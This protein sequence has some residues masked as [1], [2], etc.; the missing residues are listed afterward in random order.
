MD[1]IGFV[2]SDF[3]GAVGVKDSGAGAIAGGARKGRGEEAECSL[4]APTTSVDNYINQRQPNQNRLNYRKEIASSENSSTPSANY[5]EEGCRHNNRT[6]QAPQLGL[7]AHDL[8]AG[9]AEKRNSR[10]PKR[11]PIHKVTVIRL[12]ADGV[13]GT[14]SFITHCAR[15]MV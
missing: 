9:K 12:R 1:A 2:P 8:P 15:R 13:V 5:D 7:T 11:P 10:I 6:R 14:Y 4:L 3:D